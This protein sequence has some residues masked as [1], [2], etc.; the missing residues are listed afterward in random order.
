MT[1]SFQQ[2]PFNY[3][4]MQL[5]LWSVFVHFVLAWNEVIGLKWLLPLPRHATCT[6]KHFCPANLFN[7]NGAAPGKNFSGEEEILVFWIPRSGPGNFVAW[8][9]L[10]LIFF[11]RSSRVLLIWMLKPHI[12]LVVDVWAW[13]FRYSSWFFIIIGKCT[14]MNSQDWKLSGKLALLKVQF[15]WGFS[16]SWTLRPWKEYIFELIG[17]DFLIFYT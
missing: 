3:L 12:S 15:G 6:L 8:Q 9:F 5:P 14:F 2:S 11:H 16:S 1:S 4:G 17:Y 13:I 7:F 10:R